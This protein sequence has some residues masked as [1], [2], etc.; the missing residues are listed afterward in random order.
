MADNNLYPY[1]KRSRSKRRPRRR[2]GLRSS[3]RRLGWS[4]FICTLVGYGTG[5]LFN[6]VP[7]GIAIGLTIGLAV[8]ILIAG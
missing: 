7:V 5:L 8:G 2:R 4:M 3:Q 1:K 6:N